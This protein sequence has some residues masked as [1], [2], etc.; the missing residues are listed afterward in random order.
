MVNLPC[1]HMC[2]SY[3]YYE[4]C[5]IICAVSYVQFIIMCS[6]KCAVSNVQYHMCSIICSVS[7]AQYHMC[8]IIC[9]VQICS[10]ITRG[11]VRRGEFHPHMI[12]SYLHLLNY[13]VN[14]LFTHQKNTVVEYL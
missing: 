9:A 5:S 2:S 8:T 4:M 11:R 14:I 1:N 12:R 10:G 6:I 13:F 3:V 7:Y